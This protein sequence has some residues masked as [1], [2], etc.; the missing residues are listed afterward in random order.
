[1]KVKVTLA[2]NTGADVGSFS[3]YSNADGY[4]TAFATSVSRTALLAGYTSTNAPT[5][6]TTVRVVSTGNCT[7]SI[8]LPVEPLIGLIS[9]YNINANGA[10]ARLTGVS[11][12]GTPI[13]LDPAYSWPIYPNTSAIATYSIPS[14]TSHTIEVS[15]SHGADTPVRVGLSTGQV[16]CDVSSGYQEFSGNNLSTRPSL[17]ITLDVEGT[18]C[19]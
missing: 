7:T 13:T 1:M 6:T 18:A 4:V 2:S 16:Y 8:D 11:I 19:S 14:G 15:S 10:N 12:N 3:L 17:S 9:L 5:G